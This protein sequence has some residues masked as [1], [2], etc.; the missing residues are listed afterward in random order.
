MNIQ[1]PVSE[2]YI[3]GRNGVFDLTAIQVWQAEGHEGK[4][5]IDG[6]GKRGNPIRGGIGRVPV[7][8]FEQLCI[9]F[10]KARGYTVTEPDLRTPRERLMDD[11]WAEIDCMEQEDSDTDYYAVIQAALD[12]ASDYRLGIILSIYQD[13]DDSEGN[14]LRHEWAMEKLFEGDTK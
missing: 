4:V 1:Q 12:A 6:I 8:E 9:A 7:G 5:F 3:Q 13:Y 10:L 14:S 11:I 2:G